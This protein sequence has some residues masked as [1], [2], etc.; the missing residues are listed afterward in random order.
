MRKLLTPLLLITLAPAA[1]RATEMEE[2]PTPP[3]QSDKATPKTVAPPTVAAPPADPQAEWDHHFIGFEDWVAYN[4]HTGAIVNAWSKPVEGKY[5]KPL[6]Y[7]DF[8]EKVGRADLAGRYRT[9]RSVKIGLGVAGGVALVGGFVAI[10]AQFMSN[11]DAWDTCFNANFHLGG[12]AAGCS[13]TAGNG[14]Y[15][16]GGLLLGV[17]FAGVLA[18]IVTPLQPAQPYEAREL[19]DQYNKQL[20]DQLGLDRAPAPKPAPSDATTVTL[21]PSVD[22]KGAGLKLVARF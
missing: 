3:A 21:V 11:S 15:V 9:R 5:R 8:Y 4:V 13:D 7:A 17:G 16:A 18:A 1:A 22:S 10:I 20:R 14:G 2:I 19:A 12:N 6:A